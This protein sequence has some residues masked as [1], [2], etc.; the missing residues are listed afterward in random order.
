MVTCAEWSC[1]GNGGM[2]KV[3]T[4][5]NGHVENGDM[6]GMVT[7]RHKWLLVRNGHVVWGIVVCVRWL[8]VRNRHVRNGDMW[9]MV[10][11]MKCYMCVQ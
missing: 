4:L 2:C 6:W 7:I 1:V 5:W 11:Y 9:G 10:V 3:V 8:H